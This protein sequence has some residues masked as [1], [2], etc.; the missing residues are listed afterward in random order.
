MK[1]YLVCGNWDGEKYTA[2][3]GAYEIINRIDMN[4]CIGEEL[5]IYNVEFGKEP[6]RL[7]IHGAWHDAKNP[8]YIKVT[9][10]NGEI[11]FDGMGTD[12]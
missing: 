11:E 2:L 3:M 4:D 5:E 6:E 10:E 12:H 8:L 1:K 7:T 9:R